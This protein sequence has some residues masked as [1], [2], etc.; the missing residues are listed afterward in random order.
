MSLGTCGLF[1]DLASEFEREVAQRLETRK[2]WFGV[3][4]CFLKLGLEMTW[5]T[6]ECSLNSGSE[7]CSVSSPTFQSRA[8]SAFICLFRHLFIWLACLYLRAPCLLSLLPVR[9]CQCRVL[10]Y[11]GI[12]TRTDT[13]FRADGWELVLNTILF[14]SP[15]SWQIME[16]QAGCRCRK[17]LL[18]RRLVD[19]ETVFLTVLFL[20]RRIHHGSPMWG[21]DAK[22]KIIAW[23][24]A[25]DRQIWVGFDGSGQ[26]HT[27]CAILKNKLFY[28]KLQFQRLARV[29][30]PS[31]REGL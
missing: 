18:S 24:L 17:L 14:F 28:S 10:C 2:V 1:K 11:R 23:R 7:I 27:D 26:S 15:H 3:C 21:V 29:P 30:Q 5:G 20:Y 8:I 9:G 16:G 12:K 22:S 25:A 31:I 6:Q 4:F 19:Q 13:L